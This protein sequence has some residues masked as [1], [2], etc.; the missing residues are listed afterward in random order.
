MLRCQ[1]IVEQADMHLTQEQTIFN[2]ILF[3]IHLFA[4]SNCRLYIKQ[5]KAM[6]TQI[7]KI[8]T[9]SKV[10]DTQQMIID[11]KIKLNQGDK[12]GQ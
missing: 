7:S 4:C 11:I 6:L 9:S 2:K 10:K 5:F 1:D 8:A 12:N 3:K